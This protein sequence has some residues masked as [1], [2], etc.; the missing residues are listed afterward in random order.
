MSKKKK[1]TPFIIGIIVTPLPT[2]LT[3]HPETCEYVRLV[4]KGEFRLQMEVGL[5]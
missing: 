5:K 1:Y 2:R 4:G 3:V